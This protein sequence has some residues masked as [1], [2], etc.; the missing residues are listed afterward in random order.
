[1][2]VAGSWSISSAPGWPSC[3]TERSRSRPASCSGCAT[4]RNPTKDQL[5]AVLGERGPETYRWWKTGLDRA[6]SV[7]AIYHRLGGRIGTGFLVR[8][9][10]LG[11]AAS[12]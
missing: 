6:L 10:D 11:L 7:A 2:T 4:S 8:A 12:R 5:E 9:A 1:M 3:Q